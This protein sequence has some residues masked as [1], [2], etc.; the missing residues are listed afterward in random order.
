MLL[1]SSSRSPLFL[2]ALLLSAVLPSVRGDVKM[3]AI[4]GDHMVLQQE[5]KLPVW[6]W[7]AAGEKVTVAFGQRTGNAVASAAD[8]TWRVELPPLGPESK[9]GTLIVT[10]NNR[11][12]FEDV[13][14]GD[15]WI[16]A[17]QSNMEFGIQ[18]DRDAAEAIAQAHDSQIRLF[19]VPWATSLEPAP[20]LGAERRGVAYAGKWQ[21]CTPELMGAPW[22]WHGFSA[23][24]YYFAKEIRHAT[25]R[26]IGVIGAYKGGTKAQAWTSLAGLQAEPALAHYLADRQKIVADYPKAVHEYS[27]KMADYQAALKQWNAQGGKAFKEAMALWKTAV[28]AA[29]AAGQ[30][31]PPVPQPAKPEPL[32]PRP[33]DGGYG[34]PGTLFNAMVSPLIPYAIKGVI[35]YQGES[36]G[37][38]LDQAREYD[39]LFP[40]LIKDWREQWKQGDFPFLFVQLANFRAPAQTPSEGIWAW[41]REAQRNALSLPRTGMAVIVDIGDP[42]N[43]HPQD[44]FD[45]GKRLALVARRVAYGENVVDAGPAY[46]SMTV[47]G[48]KI[49]LAFKHGGDGLALGVPPWTPAGAPPS[50]PTE[51]VG[52]GIAG[53]DQKFVWAK[54]HI[55]GNTVVVACD[56]VAHPVAVRYNWADNPAGNLYNQAGLPASPFRTDP[57]PCSLPTATVPATK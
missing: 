29:K 20:S 28:Q 24:G 57:W 39:V 48:D 14:V 34:T 36:N 44:K 40:R 4:F 3:P 11:L 2:S 41:V 35:W 9:P 7:A 12:V 38:R 10:G 27:G 46:D 45:V 37:D 25:G 6:G 1:A 19:F 13:L 31:Q 47:E 49:R 17:G 15:V 56:S 52:F 32:A 30:P 5:A 23:V 18:T 42:G 26:P 55:E 53:A 51:L 50:S 43:I 54:A 22:A 21:V 33:P 16:A 8:G